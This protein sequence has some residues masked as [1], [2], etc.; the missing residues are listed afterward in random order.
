MTFKPAVDWVVSL[1]FFGKIITADVGEPDMTSQV[2]G[3]FEW[4]SLLEL[5][6]AE[7]EW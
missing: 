1:G 5:D 2:A 4:L 6:R 7:A 3:E